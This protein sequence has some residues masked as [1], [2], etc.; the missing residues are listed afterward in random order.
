MKISY[1]KRSG[2]SVVLVLTFFAIYFKHSDFV[3]VNI[4]KSQWPLSNSGQR[5]NGK[6]G[7]QG[8]DIN[9]QNA[10]KIS[11]GDK[12]VI[13]G[14][15]D[16]GIESTC[17]NIYKNEYELMD[18]VDNDK[19][20]YIDD[21]SGWNFFCG[22]NVI[23]D[24]YV[25]DYHGTY[26]SNIIVGKADYLGVAPD[27]TILPLKFM[28]GTEGDT[29]DAVNA[30]IYAH[31]SG[32]KIINCSW[33]FNEYDEKLYATMKKYDDILFICAAGKTNLN[34]DE[35][36]L[37]PA[38]YE[39]DNIIS[40]MAVDN[41]GKKYEYSGYGESVDVA[42]PGVDVVC[43]LPEGDEKMCSGTSIA[44]AYVSGI[45][46]LI[47]STNKDLKSNEVADILKRNTRKV[48]SLQELIGSGGIIDAYQCLKDAK[49]RKNILRN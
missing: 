9:I 12:E 17:N 48:D 38:S 8:Y 15:L 34:L 5:I 16:S 32:A 11:K 43:K 27:V 7:I 2:L 23:Y 26:I 20:G 10:W 13:V 4:S 28:S 1:K 46:S 45:A 36:H 47:L 21:V 29:A 14:I 44:T 49:S 30:I 6:K 3:N 35:S 25:N 33:D 41:Q 42:A 39:L 18:G 40:V 37:Y 22:N 19:N 24:G 31:N